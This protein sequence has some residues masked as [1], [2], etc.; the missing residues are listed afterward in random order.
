MLVRQWGACTGALART[1]PQSGP[2]RPKM[3]TW[4]RSTPLSRGASLSCAAQLGQ[5]ATATRPCVTQ[6][7]G[8]A[9]ACV[10]WGLHAGPALPQCQ[11]WLPLVMT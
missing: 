4:Q 1:W 11:Y 8:K 3:H 5:G 7:C 6:L 9:A 2:S 10:V